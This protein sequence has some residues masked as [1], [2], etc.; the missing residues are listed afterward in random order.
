MRYNI[1]FSHFVEFST[2]MHYYPKKL[3]FNSSAKL[4]AYF[5]RYQLS[6]IS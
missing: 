6:A 2:E 3:C 4:Q 5:N 1:K